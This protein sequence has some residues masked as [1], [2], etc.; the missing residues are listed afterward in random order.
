MKIS[1]F[2]TR[3]IGEPDTKYE[4]NF[5]RNKKKCNKFKNKKQGKKEKQ[6]NK[7]CSHTCYFKFQNFKKQCWLSKSRH[8][9]W[10]FPEQGWPIFKQDILQD[11]KI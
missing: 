3:V 7:T 8:S 9:H 5:R 2:R 10:G 11:I 6:K 1:T 4:Q